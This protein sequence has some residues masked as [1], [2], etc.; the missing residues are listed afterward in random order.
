[1]SA[2]PKKPVLSAAGHFWATLRKPMISGL[3]V[4]IPL[5][6]TVFVLKLLYDFTAGRI[7]PFIRDHVYSIPDVA[8]PLVACIFLFL[9]VYF[10]GMI[11]GVVAGRKTIRMVET[12]I[13]RIP[14]VKSIYSASK[15]VVLSL[16]FQRR[17]AEPKT[18][19]IVEFPHR[20]MRVIGFLL[21]RAC[22]QDGRELLRVFIP[23]TPNITVGFLQLL[24][25]EE[26]Y[27]CGL[28]IDEAVKMIVSGGIL[29]PNLLTLTPFAN[30]P[31]ASTTTQSDDDDDE[32][33]WY[34]D[35]D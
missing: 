12:L 15:Q 17:R 11:A 2:N 31:P 22:F 24:P 19:V 3:L 32:Y 30:M 1:M 29:G 28:S 6:I 8:S 25:P 27:E 10:A 16:A 26:V 13:A 18:P 35:D 9:L 20:G 23:T 21:G 34:N 14:F 7:S 33:E 5:A 4:V